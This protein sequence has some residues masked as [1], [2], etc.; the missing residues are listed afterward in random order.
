MSATG[1][2]QVFAGRREAGAA[3]SALLAGRE[4]TD[5]VVVAMP[6]GGVPVA[7]VVAA[8]LD[9]ALDIAV[10]RKLGAPRQPELAIGAIGEDDALVLDEAT[11]EA[12]K[13]GPEAVERVW[14]RERDELERRVALYRAECPR[15]DL[16]GRD[17]ILVDDGLATGATAAAAARSLRSRGATRIVLAV[18]VC[19]AETVG[20]PPDPTIDELVCV[21]APEQMQ[22]VGYWYERFPQVSDA[23]VLAELRAWPAR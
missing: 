1:R 16:R 5:P 15:V 18:P 8:R 21:L 20:H 12:L 6:R 19:P 3:L 11:I 22:A 23:E 10:V 2:N 14:R 13:I 7:S 9:A 17:A 4:F